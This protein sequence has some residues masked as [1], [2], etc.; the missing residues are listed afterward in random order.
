VVN[1]FVWM[2]SSYWLWRVLYTQK[3]GAFGISLEQMVTYALLSAVISVAIRPA[4][5]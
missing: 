3:A 2:F 5:V 4:G 1:N